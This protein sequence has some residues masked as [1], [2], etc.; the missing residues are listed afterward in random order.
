GKLN[1]G[2]VNYEGI[3]YYNNLINEILANGIT[4]YVT[5]FHWDLPQVLV[6]EYGGFLSEKIVEDF[7]YYAGVCFKHFGDRV[8]NWITLNEPW[9]YSVYGYDTGVMSPGRCSSWYNVNC[10]GGNSGRE[11]YIVTHNLILSHATAVQL[12]RNKYKP[13]QKGRIGIT[14]VAQWYEPCNVSNGDEAAVYRKLEF[15]LGW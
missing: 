15:M 12:Y 10:T 14:L 7:E 6:D 13:R 4:P 8:K 1:G 2:Q 3:N 11:P 5:L 9:T